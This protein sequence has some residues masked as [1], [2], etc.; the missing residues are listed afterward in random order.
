[1]DAERPVVATGRW[2]TIDVVGA[3][4]SVDEGRLDVRGKKLEGVR[5]ERST[6]G[7]TPQTGE[8]ACTDPKPEGAIESCGVVDN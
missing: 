3:T 6:S 8:D 2:P 4:V 1:M 7:A 5:F